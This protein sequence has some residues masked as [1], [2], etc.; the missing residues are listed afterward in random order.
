MCGE[1]VEG[2]G[3]EDGGGVGLGVAPGLEEWGELLEVGD[4]VD[5]CG[6]LLVAEEAVEV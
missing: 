2:V 1:E 4:G 3:G 6:G 5:L